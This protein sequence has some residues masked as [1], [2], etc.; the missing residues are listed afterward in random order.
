MLMLAGV[1]RLGFVLLLPL[2]PK[3]PEWWVACATPMWGSW[4]RVGGAGMLVA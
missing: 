2:L 3:F 4:G 1:G